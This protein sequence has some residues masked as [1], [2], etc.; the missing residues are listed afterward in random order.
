LETQ[1]K[2]LQS[3]LSS[4]SFYYFT[5]ENNSWYPEPEHYIPLPSL[6]S[7]P[8]LPN[9][10][11]PEKEVEQIRNF[12]HVHGAA[13]R[14]RTNQQ[15]TTVAGHGTIPEVIYQRHLHTS[16]RV[17]VSGVARST[18]SRAEHFDEMPD[19][20]RLN[21]SDADEADEADDEVIE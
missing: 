11:L 9:V 6:P 8:P 4:S 19:C 3:G 18:A 21:A 15:E 5:S 17:D 12:S 10:K 13:V 7:I 2:K 20:G 1:S 14:Q 16:E